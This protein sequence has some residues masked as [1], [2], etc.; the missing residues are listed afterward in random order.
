MIINTPEEHIR[1]LENNLLIPI[2]KVMASQDTVFGF[3]LMGQAIEI[4]G[5]YLD[6]KPIRAKQQSASRFS[7]AIYKLFPPKYAEINKNNALYIQLRACLTHTFIPSGNVSL[8]FGFDETK[9][10]HLKLEN[11]VLY[12]Y[13]E[14]LYSDLTNA[15][16]QLI[17]N[18]RLYKIRLKKL[19]IG[20]VNLNQNRQV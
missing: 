12:L 2:R 3:M 19:S 15:V 4:L 13:S 1:F 9:K 14:N 8:N 11:D 5:S 20:E 17:T 6:N 18:I 7:L 16:K 10:H